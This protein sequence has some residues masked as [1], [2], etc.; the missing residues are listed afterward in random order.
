M[1]DLRFLRRFLIFYLIL[2]S[3]ASFSQT[4]DLQM[5]DLLFQDLDCGEICDAIEEVTASA[6][7][8][9]YSHV[10][11]LDFDGTDFYALEAIGR[12]VQKIPLRAFLKRSPNGKVDRMRVPNADQGDLSLAV[13]WIKNKV[14]V[15]YDPYFSM[16]EDAFYCSELI[17]TA[18]SK[19]VGLQ[20]IFQLRKMTFKTKNSNQIHPVW[21]KY[22]D[23]LKVPVPEGQWGL[24]PVDM[25]R[26]LIRLDFHQVEP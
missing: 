14:G 15:P 17:Y 19:V 1:S 21:Q 4:N 9:R 20:N 24:N 25:S 12:V 6:D 8:R 26:V 23:Q 7:G 16:G 3:A 2:S 11:I 13:D 10:A 18:F 22:F 5:G